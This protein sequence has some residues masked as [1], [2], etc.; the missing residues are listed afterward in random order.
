MPKPKVA[1]AFASGNHPN[2]EKTD[3][4]PTPPAFTAALL[5][6]EHFHHHIWEPACGRGDISKVAEN[7]GYSVFNSDIEPRMEGGLGWNFFESTINTPDGVDIITNP[8]FSVAREFMIRMCQL[9]YRKAAVV[10]PLQALTGTYRVQELWKPYPP[11]KVYINPK[12]MLIEGCDGREDV[13]SQF[14]HI[15]VVYDRKHRGPTQ[16]HW[17]D[18]PVSGYLDEV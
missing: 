2:R 14:M 8:P 13:K 3:F 5:D 12:F 9:C 11:S 16:L 4:Y 6:R 18:P 10:M 1:G 7:F 17:I 15:W